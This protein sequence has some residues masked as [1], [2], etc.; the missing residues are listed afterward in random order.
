[1]LENFKQQQNKKHFFILKNHN[2]TDNST[3][4]KANIELQ[5]L[6]LKVN[7]QIEGD[8][9]QYNFSQKTK[10]Q[11]AD[12]LWLDTCFELFIANR[13]KKEY[14]EINTSPSTE[15]NS[16]YFTGYKE[17]MRESTIFSTP[18]IITDSDESQYKLSFETTIKKGFLEKK[19]HINICVILLDRDGE[20]N[21]YSIN[22]RNNTPDFHDKVWWV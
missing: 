5:N 9:S 17:N 21:F 18:K 2:H 19:L 22:R 8:I 14:W 15:W 7:Y 13:D 1:M 11:R 4:V 16:Y 12:R 6:Q 20:R 10:Q 3:I